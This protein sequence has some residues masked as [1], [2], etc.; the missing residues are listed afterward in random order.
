MQNDIAVCVAEISHDLM[1]PQRTC[2]MALGLD[3]KYDLKKFRLSFCAVLA[4]ITDTVYPCCKHSS[5]YKKANIEG[6]H[7]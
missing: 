1:T 5:E 3:I 6:Q 7:Q 4:F 2:E